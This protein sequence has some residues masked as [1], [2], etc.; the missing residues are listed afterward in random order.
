MRQKKKMM[1]GN[2][3]KL[4]NQLFYTFE[5]FGGSDLMNVSQS[6]T[7]YCPA[8]LFGPKAEGWLPM[9]TS[10]LNKLDHIY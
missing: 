5:F 2:S 4:G 1:Q 6:G 7:P 3:K 10:S 8:L 9:I